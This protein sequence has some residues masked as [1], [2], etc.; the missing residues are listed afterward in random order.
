MSLHSTQGQSLEKKRQRRQRLGNK[1]TNKHTHTH[2]PSRTT[3]KKKTNEQHQ[4]KQIN[5][6]LGGRDAQPKHTPTYTHVYLHGHIHIY[7]H[8]STSIPRRG[9]I[10]LGSSTGRLVQRNRYIQHSQ[11]RK[12]ARIYVNT[13]ISIHIST[14]TMPA[15]RHFF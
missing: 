11:T 6:Q 12:Y 4:N 7:T 15:A 14:S 9:S 5:K 3:H 8:T 2:A 13:L 1:Q 10:R